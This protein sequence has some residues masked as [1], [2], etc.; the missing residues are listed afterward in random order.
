MD[1]TNDAFLDGRVRLKQPASGYR[2]T[3]DSVL[4]AAAVPVQKGQS[5]LDVGCASGI[6]AACVRARVGDVRLTGVEVQGDLARLARENCPDMEVVCADI[7]QRIP[8]LH[9]RQFHHVATN[10]PFYTE[11]AARRNAQQKTAFHQAV[12]LKAWLAACL[13]YVRPRGTLTLVHRMEAVPEIV[14]VLRPKLGALEVIPIVGKAGKPAERVIVR[15]VL[16]SRKPFAIHAPIIVHNA[17][18][19]P[20]DAAVALLRAGQ[21]LAAETKNTPRTKACRPDFRK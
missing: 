5:L 14:A 15:G 6:V 4:L 16:G 12:P 21:G 3:S 20:T 19:T 10:P 8:A 17:D 2:A 11:P 13:K 18:G 9:G 1:D 7:T